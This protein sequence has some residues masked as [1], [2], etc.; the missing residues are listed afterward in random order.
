V[1]TLDYNFE[2]GVLPLFSKNQFITHYT[3]H[4]DGLLAE[5]NELI[6]KSDLH[7]KTLSEIVVATAKSEDPV[8]KRIYNLACEHYSH[9]FFWNILKP[10]P[11]ENK[12]GANVLMHKIQHDFKSIEN[13]KR[14]FE[15]ACSDFFGS[16]WVWVV[17]DMKQNKVRIW[18]CERGCPLQEAGSV[19][20]FC[21]DIWEHSYYMDYQSNRGAYIANFW[22]CL[23]WG[24][25]SLIFEESLKSP[26]LTQ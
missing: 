9:A 23:D 7:Q 12:M 8:M 6:S 22:K 11:K 13:F 4:H 14:N 2:M 16:G 19:P 18:S 5:L 26:T 17:L 20:L 10:S 24:K 15:I 3:I 21:I 1:P 25:A